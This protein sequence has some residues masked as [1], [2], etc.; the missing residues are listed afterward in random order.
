MTK[1]SALTEYLNGRSELSFTISFTEL[2]HIVDLPPSAK[3]HPAWWAN[4]RNAHAHAATWLDAGFNATPDFVTGRVRF[5][6]GGDQGRGI[7]GSKQP[8]GLSPFA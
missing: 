5:Q 6:R 3:K 8:R 4:S 1:Y 7:G 2:D